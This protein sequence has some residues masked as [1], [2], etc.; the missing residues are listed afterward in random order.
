MIPQS[1]KM[2][3]KINVKLVESVKKTIYGRILSLKVLLKLFQL[4]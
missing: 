1:E 3:I 4:S 2:G